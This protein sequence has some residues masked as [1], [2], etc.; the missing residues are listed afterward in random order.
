MIKL[1][2]YNTLVAARRMEQGIYLEDDLNNSV[3]LP[4]RYVPKDIQLADELTVFVY[5][6]SEDRIVATTLIPHLTLGKFALLEVVSVT[7][8]GAFL[9]WGLAKDIFI[10][11]SEQLHKLREGDRAIVTL[12][13]DTV[14]QRLVASAKLNR[15]LQNENILLKE[16]QE[17]DLLIADYTD[18]GVNV[19]IN[20]TY[21]GILY[22]NEIFKHIQQ[23]DKVKGYIKKIREDQ[24]IDVSLQ[25]QGY[26]NVT[27]NEEII[28]AKLKEHNGFLPL[29]DDSPPEKITATL[30]MSKKTFK[31]AIGALFRQRLIRIE[32][33]GICLNKGK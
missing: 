2:E 15:F 10:P 6:D 11:F 27:S 5:N 18:I 1:G 14:T 23:G 29:N 9:D 19:I 17:V 33:N 13:L 30:E 21:K 8:H 3:L 24:K 26:E 32:E 22:K 4:N 28:L 16:N 12:Y 25:K 20:N 31:K 7:P